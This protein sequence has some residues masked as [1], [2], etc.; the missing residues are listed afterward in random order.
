[1]KRFNSIW[2]TLRAFISAI[3]CWAVVGD[4]VLAAANDGGAGEDKG[5]GVWVMAYMLVILFM[6]LGM[7]F[8]LRSAKRRDRAKPEKYAEIKPAEKYG[9]KRE[10]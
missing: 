1:M 9:K 4:S 10:E 7:L 2:K 8:V 6:V 5:Y 3:G